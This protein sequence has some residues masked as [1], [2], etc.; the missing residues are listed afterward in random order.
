MTEPTQN[1]WYF[2][3]SV[4]VI[5]VMVA[6]PLALP[7]LWF[8]PRYKNFTKIIWTIVIIALSYYST[9][10]MV[11]SFNNIKKYYDLAFNPVGLQ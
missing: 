9:L 11:E 1:P 6:G 4:L 8:N 7:L 3:T 5:A 2:K 10:L